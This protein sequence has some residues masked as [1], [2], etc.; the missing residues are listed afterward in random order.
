MANPM[1]EWVA[2]AA[3]SPGQLRSALSHAGTLSILSS[4]AWAAGQLMFVPPHNPGLTFLILTLRT[5]AFYSVA[6]VL[7]GLSITV[8]MTMY[9]ARRDARRAMV[10]AGFGATPVLVC[11][12]LTVYPLLAIVTVMAVPLAGYQL[13][14]GAQ[15]VAG[16][17]PADAAEFVAVSMVLATLV[18]IA[19]GGVLGSLGLL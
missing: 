3:I 10:L 18:S 1:T 4:I 11:G 17:R 15:I 16:V 2:I 5:F 12:L 6:I 13:H 7:L 8:L 14:V 9:G 19:A